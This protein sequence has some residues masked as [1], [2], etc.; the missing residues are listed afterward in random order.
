MKSP[1]GYMDDTVIFSNNREY[2]KSVKELLEWYINTLT[3]L[4]FSRWSIQNISRGVNFLGYRIWPTHKLIRKNSATKAK[5]KLKQL[6]G[7][8][9]AKFKAAWGGHIQWA[10]THNLTGAITA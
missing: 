5:R 9:L 3:G 6:T 7:E 4:K 1:L 8:S 2:L 10:D